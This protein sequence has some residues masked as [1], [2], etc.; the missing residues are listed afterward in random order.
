MDDNEDSL[1]EFVGGQD[2]IQMILTLLADFQDP[3]ANKI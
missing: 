2:F 1:D 3:K